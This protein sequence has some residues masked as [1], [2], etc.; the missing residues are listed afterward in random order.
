MRH[1]A[2]ILIGFLCVSALPAD[3]DPTWNQWRGPERDGSSAGSPWPDDLDG[4][5]PVWRIELGKGYPGPVLDRDRVYVVET[6]ADEDVAVRALSRTDGAEVW[7]TTWASKGSVPFFAARNGDWVRSTPALHDGSLLVGDMQESLVALD[8]AT[9]AERWR[10]DFPDRF[11]TPVPDFGFASSPLPDGDDIYVQAAN[12]VVK[13]RAADGTT[14]WRAL[15]STGAMTQS[16]AFSSPVIAEIAGTRQLVVLTRSALYGLDLA[17][18]DALWSHELPS[19]RGMHILTPVVVGDTVF[20]SPYRNGSYLVT[21]RKGAAGFETSEAWTNPASGY[22]STPVVV[23][24]HIYLHL[25]NNRL[26]CI[27]LADGKS[28]WRT[29]S[30]GAYWSMVVRD[31]KILALDSGGALHL[32]RADTEQFE[33]LDSREISDQQAWGHLAVDGDGVYVRELKAIAA[34]RFRN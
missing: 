30:F 12:S 4:L 23:D 14:V 33:L 16:G 7:R 28:R 3:D 9:G 5:E 24:G 21:V 19:F 20:T 2:W 22:M 15:E 29:T 26:D 34:Y 6:I 8:A 18:G 27:D 1:V 17:T 13:I 31:D 32:V 25:G 11:G 10:V